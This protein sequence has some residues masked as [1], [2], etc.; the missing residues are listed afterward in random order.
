MN[1]A[2]I[3]AAF[4]KKVLWRHHA[5][6]TTLVIDELGLQHGRRRA[7]I[8]VVNGHLNGF[9]IKSNKDSLSRLGGQVKAYTAVFDKASIVVEERHLP[10]VQALVPVWWGIVVCTRGPRGAISFESIRRSLTNQTVDLF[11]VAQLLWRN[12]AAEI[13]EDM[14][15]PMRVLRSKRAVLY[16]HLIELI[17]PH[18]LRRMV[19]EQIKKRAGWRRPIR[20]CGDDGLSQPASR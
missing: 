4:H 15:I 12:E 8:A 6:S 20:P 13:L 17:D 19:R 3:R 7:D 14:A 2:Q 18:E 11:S 16:E 10:G 5:N 9:E 1:D